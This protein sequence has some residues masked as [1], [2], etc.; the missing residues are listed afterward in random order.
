MAAQIDHNRNI[1]VIPRDI[2]QKCTEDLPL[3]RTRVLR[4][5][6]VT[7]RKRPFN[8]AAS[9][10][11]PAR[12][13][14]QGYG[15]HCPISPLTPA[16][17]SCRPTLVDLTAA[18]TPATSLSFPSSPS[19][20]SSLSPYSSS[21]SSST[22]SSS[23][24][25]SASIARSVAQQGAVFKHGQG[26][27]AVTIGGHITTIHLKNLLVPPKKRKLSA[28]LASHPSQEHPGKTLSPGIKKP[29]LDLN[30]QQHRGARSVSPA[31]APAREIIVISS[32]DEIE[33]T[34][35]TTPNPATP[36]S[37][38][39]AERNHKYRIASEFRRVVDTIFPAFEVQH[40]ATLERAYATSRIL[41]EN[42]IVTRYLGSGASGFVLAAKR[43]FDGREV[44][45]KVIP[46]TGDHVEQ[47]VQRELGILL[48]LKEHENILAFLDHFT[49]S[50]YGD[51]D[52][53]DQS[54]KDISYIVTEMAGFSLFDFIELHKPIQDEDASTRSK[55][56][57][58]LP[59]STSSSP[60]V[61]GSA[62]QED[63]VRSIFTQLAL[64]LHSM[65]SQN[66]VH[67]DVKDENALISIDRST[68]TYRAKLCD[69]GHS[70]YLQ[71]GSSPCFSFYG[72]T[73]LAPPEMDN[74]VA[75][76]QK[77]K[78]PNRRSG[79]Q[80][81]TWDLF[82]GYEADVWAL[83]LT[84]Y[85]M[86]HGDLPKEL[87][88]TDSKKLAFYKRRRA[89]RR[90]FP[91]TLQENINPDLEELLKSMLAVDPARRLTMSQ[92]VNHRW[93][94]NESQ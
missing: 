36:T 15:Q 24:E 75:A 92:V 65:H 84:L 54:N 72:T 37:A 61:Y 34:P 67:G 64:A 19:L 62:I 86:I 40:K 32:D 91:F 38:P 4:A 81:T 29:R 30:T 5:R 89:S 57:Q 83:G 11:S 73:I 78:E 82:Y 33:A 22:T 25:A 17:I 1:I 63:D 50:L 46:H 56:I 80:S 35:G 87:Y 23:F 44:A 85:T 76:R 28:A 47:K 59:R 31:K 39:T 77:S 43:V 9:E 45:I 18:C 93:I 79:N 58:E 12:P 13:S 6:D 74:N 66:I 8:N 90:M 42:Y 71:P 21:S 27:N 7:S 10:R 51:I 16:S 52:P 49:S 53:E 55:N 70:K 60:S 3:P 48:R 94:L 26:N 41:R 20:T 88:E 2:Y 14:P 68:N 69:F